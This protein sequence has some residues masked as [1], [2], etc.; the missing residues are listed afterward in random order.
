MTIRNTFR[1]C[2]LSVLVSAVSVTA[3]AAPPTFQI[4]QI[5][6]NLDGT[7]QFIRLDETAGLNGQHL[8]AGLTLTSTHN[9]IVK[10]FTFP[11]DLPSD[12]T[13]NMSILVAATHGSQYLPVLFGTGGWY[14]CSPPD[15][16]MPERF[17]STE[18]GTI[19]FAGVDRM[20]YASLPTDGESGLYRDGMV[21][22]ARVPGGRCPVAN[23]PQCPRDA[24]IAQTEVTAIEYY[25]ADLAHYFISASAPDIE[26]LDSGRIRGWQRTAL[27]IP[28]AAIATVLPGTRPPVSSPAGL[29]QPV[30]RFYIPP[31]KGDSHFFSAS[32]DECA[33]VRARFPDFALESDAAFYVSLP[34][35]TTGQCPPQYFDLNDNVYTWIPVFRLW[36]QRVDSNHRYT[37]N[38]FVR[39]LMVGQGFVSEGYGPASVAFCVPQANLS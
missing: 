30:C 1:R 21:R 23:P 22:R 7:V 9:G 35:L 33:E 3:N 26:A 29:I 2:L 19:D 14:C 4:S 25:N 36:N 11:S 16:V 34:D 32:L 5:F 28:V 38:V 18:G 13:A 12:Q 20:P 31:D 15:F 27:T 8:F 17:L 39:N 10:Q 6:S 37:T 24:A